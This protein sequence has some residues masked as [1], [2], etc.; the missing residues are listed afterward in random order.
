MVPFVASCQVGISKA[1]GRGGQP[2]HPGGD[3][4]LIV[5]NN[6]RNHPVRERDVEPLEQHKHVVPAENHRV[7]RCSQQTPVSP[8][9]DHAGDLRPGEAHRG[10]QEGHQRQG[11]PFEGC[12]TKQKCQ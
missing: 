2:D 9:Q 7:E 1:S 8:E 5:N 6:N 11:S 10:P 12:S 3:S 4:N